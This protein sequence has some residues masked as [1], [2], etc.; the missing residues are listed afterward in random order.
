M[1]HR[2]LF[3]CPPVFLAP[4]H[5]AQC[6]GGPPLVCIYEL[7]CLWIQVGATKERHQQEIWG[8]GEIQVED[9][10]PRL[11]YFA[12]SW[13][14]LPKT[15]APHCHSAPGYSLWIP[16]TLSSPS[17]LGVVM[18]P[19]AAV[20]PLAPS[21]LAPPLT[22]TFTEVPLLSCHSPGLSAP[23]LLAKTLTERHPHRDLGQDPVSKSF[24]GRVCG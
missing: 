16:G 24:S 6:P 9:F 3:F 7:P 22:H 21:L 5:P 23:S 15:V 18:V 20:I 17:E 1:S 4:E 8:R 12:T 19:G 11:C 10:F 14:L 13:P 2:I